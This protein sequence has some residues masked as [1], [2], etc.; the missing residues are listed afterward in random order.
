MDQD[1]K[2]E[3]GLLR[4]EEKATTEDFD[5]YEIDRIQNRYERW[6]WGE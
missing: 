2:D 6:M 1:D 4:A 3:R 5:H